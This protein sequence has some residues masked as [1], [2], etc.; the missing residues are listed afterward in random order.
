MLQHFKLCESMI[1]KESYSECATVFSN[2]FMNPDISCCIWK[3]LLHLSN[4]YNCSRECISFYMNMFVVV[5]IFLLMLLTLSGSSQMILAGLP[6]LLY[7][8]QIIFIWYWA[9]RE[10]K[11]FNSRQSLPRLDFLGINAIKS[12]SRVVE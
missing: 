12:L 6:A 1:S 4:F 7:Y 9:L 3:E 11:E 10:G 8:L 2:H 5:S